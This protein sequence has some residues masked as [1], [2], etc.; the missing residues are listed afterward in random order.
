MATKKQPEPEKPV[1]ISLGPT[2][3][4]IAAGLAAFFVLPVLLGLT[5]LQGRL[6]Q[7]VVLFMG[8]S[9]NGAE[10]LGIMAGVVFFLV[11]GIAASLFIQTWLE[12][13][14]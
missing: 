13:H 7:A 10:F 4:T 5:F 3:L 6:V 11:V 1:S 14:L 9:E 12:E 2:Q 8:G